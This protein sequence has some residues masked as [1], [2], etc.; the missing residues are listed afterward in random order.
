MKWFHDPKRVYTKADYTEEDLLQY[1]LDHLNAAKKLF[2]LSGRQQWD[3]IISATYLSHLGVE[4]LLKACHL[5]LFKSFKG[6]HDLKELFRPL[7][8]Q[9]IKLSK[10]NKEWLN[11]GLKH[12]VEARY[13]DQGLGP[14]IGT[15][16]WNKT[17]SLIEELKNALPREI[18]KQLAFLERYRSNVRS[19]RVL[20]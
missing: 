15:E 1:G 6:T 2:D 19:G 12:A 8:K 16:Q 5:H 9:G 11:K 14:D 7:E 13:P 10:E 20:T 4:L 3:Y 18:Q 17:A